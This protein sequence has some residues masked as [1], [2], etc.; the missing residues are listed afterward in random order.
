[1][2]AKWLVDRDRALAEE[3]AAASPGA[4]RRLAHW[5]AQRV[6]DEAGISD[7]D[8]VADAL[9]AMQRGEPLPPP[10]DDPGQM[11][12]RLAGDERAPR[13]TTTYQGHATERGPIALFATL[14]A[15]WPAALW[16]ATDTIARA[17]AV[18]GDD[19]QDVLLRETAEALRRLGPGPAA[20]PRAVT[21]TDPTTVR[22][23]PQRGPG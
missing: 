14:G 15:V 10:L 8:W 20:D 19:R 18:F 2:P 7:L 16:A 5:A 3:V 23:K 9:A 22:E 17:A 6:C 13:S 12:E 4:Q 21:T 1:V 11:Y